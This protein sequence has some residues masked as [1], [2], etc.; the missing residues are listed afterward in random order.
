MSRQFQRLAQGIKAFCSYFQVT[1]TPIELATSALGALSAGA[2]V[3]NLQDINEE[4]TNT[5]ALTFTTLAAAAATGGWLLSVWCN[6][7]YFRHS[8]YGQRETRIEAVA[9]EMMR[10]TAGIQIMQRVANAYR[11]HDFVSLAYIPA[12]F[13]FAYGVIW[14]Q[15]QEML[16]E[17]DGSIL[18]WRRRSVRQNDSP[19]KKEIIKW[20]LLQSI[21]F[22]F[23]YS[24]IDLSSEA[25]LSA[26]SSWISMLISAMVVFWRYLPIF[27]GQRGGGFQLPDG[28]FCI[29]CREHL[30]GEFSDHW[31]RAAVREGLLFLM[32]PLWIMPVYQLCV[33]SRNFSMLIQQGCFF[34]QGL[35]CSV[36][37]LMSE[38]RVP[39]ISRQVE[40]EMLIEV[41]TQKKKKNKLTRDDKSCTLIMICYPCILVVSA[42]I[43]PFQIISCLCSLLRDLFQDGEYSLTFIRGKIFTTNYEALLSLSGSLGA[44]I[45]LEGF[46]K[47]WGGDIS[48]NLD[49]IYM[50]TGGGVW[51]LGMLSNY[52]HRR[53]PLYQDY[54]RERWIET[55]ARELLKITVGGQIILGGFTKNAI[56]IAYVVYAFFIYHGIIVEHDSEL[57]NDRHH[58]FL[59]WDRQGEGGEHNELALDPYSRRDICIWL[60]DRVVEMSIGFAGKNQINEDK[61]IPKPYTTTILTLGSF[62]VMRILLVGAYGV[63]ACPNYGIENRGDHQD[64]AMGRLLPKHDFRTFKALGITSYFRRRLMIAIPMSVLG[65]LIFDM[66]EALSQHSARGV[67]GWLEGLYFI[68]GLACACL[69]ASHEIKRKPRIQP[70]ESGGEN[71]LQVT[72]MPPPRELRHPSQDATSD[73]KSDDGEKQN[74]YFMGVT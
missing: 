5:Y 34:F 71:L 73:F 74:N 14:G 21:D 41:K 69:F 56:V 43:L 6:Q 66:T 13:I 72:I 50:C 61:Y 38:K 15:H 2:L 9:R 63:I 8:Q 33:I 37:F 7:R 26:I 27:C 25:P 62:W 20:M 54:S 19:I 48:G 64:K 65:F 28:L 32:K 39:Q 52:I 12:H 46:K 42:V 60:L 11:Y 1:Q 22:L 51:L 24:A 31:Q 40:N 55:L 67:T 44:G 59:L 10:A 4:G 47:R 53:R 23:W 29:F 30:F 57:K 18:P 49:M 3:Q 16:S 45:C 58:S 70:L 36:F 68:Q 17:Y 35:A